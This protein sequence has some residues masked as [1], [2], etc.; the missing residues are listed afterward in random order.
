MLCLSLEEGSGCGDGSLVRILTSAMIFDILI[1]VF[2]VIFFH[3]S[4]NHS[5]I[6]P[7]QSRRLVRW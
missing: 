5:T 6:P 7:Y 1:I 3:Q 2:I 4:S